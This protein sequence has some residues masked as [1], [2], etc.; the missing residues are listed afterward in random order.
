LHVDDL[1]DAAIFLMNHYDSGE[2]INVGAGE[3]LSIRELAEMI[4]GVTGYT[5]QLLFDAAM[6]DCTPRKLL[7]ISLLEALGCSPRIPLRAGIVSTYEWYRHSLSE[8]VFALCRWFPGEV[9]LRD[10]QYTLG[11]RNGARLWLRGSFPPASPGR[12]KNTER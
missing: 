9:C 5:G 1:A 7:A 8:I 12:A 11:I 3:D 10:T 2:I 4:R 6:P